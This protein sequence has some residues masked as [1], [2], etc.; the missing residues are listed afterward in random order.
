M[1]LWRQGTVLWRLGPGNRGVATRQSGVRRTGRR[2]R[3]AARCWKGARARG[4]ACTG[5]ES[6]LRGR[7]PPPHP[8]PP[9]HT[10]ARN[11]ALPRCAPPQDACGRPA[12]AGEL[13]GLRARLAAL[14]AARAHGALGPPLT[15]DPGLLSR[16]VFEW[17]WADRGHR[18][19]L[20]R[21]AAAPDR[22][23]RPWPAGAGVAAPPAG[24]VPRAPAGSG[25][26]ELSMDELRVD[27]H[28][29]GG[30]GGGGG[31]LVRLAHPAPQ[32]TLPSPHWL[33]PASRLPPAS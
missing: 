7:D 17:W 18:A 24:R 4:R 33:P 11:A 31:G 14:A 1:G 20:A 25:A 16:A 13:A 19:R 28:G 29:G 12:S 3:A 6:R 21:A 30:G 23:A 10:P 9:T 22:D 2:L 5:K 8:Q 32:P 26:E 27:D 15:A